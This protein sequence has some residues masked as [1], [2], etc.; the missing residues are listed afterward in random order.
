M[1]IRAMRIRLIDA[2]GL[3]EAELRLGDTIAQ[4]VAHA[5]AIQYRDKWYS[6]KRLGWAGDYQIAV[7]TLCAHPAFLLEGAGVEVL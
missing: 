6:F 7:Y 4:Q 2:H 1:R 5:P 3:T